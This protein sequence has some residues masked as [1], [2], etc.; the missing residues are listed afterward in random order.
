MQILAARRSALATCFAFS[1]AGCATIGAGAARDRY[2]QSQLEPYRFQK[3]CAQVWPTALRVADEKRFPVVGSDRKLI[4]ESEEGFLSS[5]VSD[6]FPTH[7]TDGGL[8]AETNWNQ[9]LGIRYRIEAKPAAPSGCRVVY[10]L[11]TGGAQGDTT[12]TLGPDWEMLL[13]LVAA[14]DPPAAARIEGEAPKG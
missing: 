14:E 12:Q 3:E 5:L 2:L 10:I 11:I 6:G 1:L 7:R 9:E 8:V 4:G 13:A